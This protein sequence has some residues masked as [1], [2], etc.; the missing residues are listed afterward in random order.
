[1]SHKRSFA[2]PTT[3]QRPQRPPAGRNR[4]RPSLETL[5]DRL[6]PAV[7][8]FTEDFSDDLNLTAPGFDSW[9]ADPGTPQ[10]DGLNILNDLPR[11]GSA[12]EGPTGRQ[13]YYFVQAGRPGDPGWGLLADGNVLSITGSNLAVPQVTFT[14]P[15]PGSPGGYDT[16]EEVTGIGVSVRGFGRIDIVGVN[17]VLTTN[18]ST[19]PDW[20]RVAADRNDLL[21]GQ[22]ELGAIRS[23][24]VYSLEGVSLDI[25]SVQ[26]DH[27]EANAPPIA[28]DDFLI[29]DRRFGESEVFYP[30]ANDFDPNGDPFQIIAHSQPARG[31]VDELNGGF[32]YRANPDALA[33]PAFREDSF[34]YTIRDSQG[35][36]AT[37]TVTFWMNHRPEGN[38]DSYPVPGGVTTP[39][40]VS[41][42]DGVLANDFP[43]RDGDPVTLRLFQPPAHGTVTVGADGSFTYV[44]NHPSGFIRPDRFQYVLNDG[45]QDG[46]SVTVDIRAPN[47]PPVAGDAQ[48]FLPH[49]TPGPLRGTFGATDADGDPVESVTLVSGPT[50]GDL[51]LRAV[52]GLVEYEYTPFF[53]TDLRGSDAFTY[54]VSDGF[55]ESNV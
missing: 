13:G 44:S 8:V 35:A 26:V 10:P 50:H 25:V 9:D 39:L 17:G 6:V 1:M 22:R 21:P 29:V 27:S 42:E 45:F 47:T 53:S 7:G 3:G 40:V 37:A 19:G 41:A 30:L 51:T 46:D 11:Y 28:N 36:V 12:M 23:L 18:F 33:D 2:P 20:Q 32:R 15:T 54:R 48:W 34:T 55:A 38:A 4:F 49:G 31:T 16:S 24:S 5:E 43:D 14:L 52:N